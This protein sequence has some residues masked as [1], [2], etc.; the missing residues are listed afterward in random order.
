MWNWMPQISQL[1]SYAQGEWKTAS[2]TSL[3]STENSVWCRFASSGNAMSTEFNLWV[4]L[5]ISTMTQ[6]AFIR[7]RHSHSNS[8]RQKVRNRFD[9]W[10]KCTFKCHHTLGSLMCTN[11]SLWI[12]KCSTA[13]HTFR[14]GKKRLKRRKLSTWEI[15][16]TR[17]ESVVTRIARLK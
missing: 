2:R 13:L 17:Q 15:V 3:R 12:L 8:T 4:K 6:S 16:C 10:S 5:L 14:T 1:F 9:N 7:L 11:Q